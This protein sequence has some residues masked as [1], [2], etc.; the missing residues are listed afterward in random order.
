MTNSNAHPP[1]GSAEFWIQQ[2]GDMIKK[3]WASTA[4]CQ[5]D[6]E[7]LGTHEKRQQLIEANQSLIEGLQKRIEHLQ[8][9]QAETYPP[10]TYND[11]HQFLTGHSIPH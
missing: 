4:V 7:W 3:A 1:F 9:N 8:K 5:L 2:C 11:I 6:V 10:E